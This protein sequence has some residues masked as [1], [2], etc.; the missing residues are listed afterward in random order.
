[1]DGAAPQTFDEGW[2][3]KGRWNELTYM[4]DRHPM[5]RYT[6]IRD[7]PHA[8]MHEQSERIWADFFCRVRK[9]KDTGIL[10]WV[11]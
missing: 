9:E 8:T 7:F 11:D 10:R 1:M 5:I 3:V 2:Q 4:K 6:W